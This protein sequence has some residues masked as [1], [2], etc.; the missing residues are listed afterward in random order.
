MNIPTSIEAIVVI[1]LV[2]I[3]GYMFL[4]FAKNT[5]AFLPKDVDARYFF[6]LIVWGGLI[7]APASHWTLRIIDWY[8]LG[9]L[10]E[11]S[12]YLI[13]WAVIVL[14]VFPVLLGSVCAWLLTLSWIDRPLR[15][16]HLDYIHRIPSAWNFA[17]RT[18]GAYVKVHL[19]DGTIIAGAYSS[20]SLA[21][22]NGDRD[23]FL[24]TVY[25]L[26]A[27]GD[28]DDVV[29][30][31]AG[32]W[33]PRDSISHLLFFRS[34]PREANDEHSD[35]STKRNR[36]DPNPNVGREGRTTLR[37]TRSG[38]SQESEAGGCEAGKPDEGPD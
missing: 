6:S 11:H 24:E 18:G 13:T 1:V 37:E 12:T 8:A 10:R 9:D 5:V 22:D 36:A 28:F 34:S 38:A 2:F 20:K 15:L 4:Q 31:S 26:D 16:I 3:P 14:V 19:K 32:V 27:N 21:D 30:D 7:H 17:I 33:I 23:L 35:S 25:N 29:A